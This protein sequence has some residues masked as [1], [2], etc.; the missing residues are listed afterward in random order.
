M[1]SNGPNHERIWGQNFPST[2]EAV[3]EACRALRQWLSRGDGRSRVFDIEL[4]AREC[5]NNAVLHGNGSEPIKRVT[6]RVWL[7]PRWIR[8][9]V[10][11]EGPG[12]DW[13]LVTRKVL[14]DASLTDG[15]GLQICRKYGR[16]VVFRGSGN[17]IFVWFDYQPTVSRHE[18]IH[19]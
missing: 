9:E 6:L 12:F 3:E 4:V 14:R 17:C 10:V 5:L 18:F 19:S 8:L 7:G 11:D 1:K 15:R 13:R 2:L 16:R